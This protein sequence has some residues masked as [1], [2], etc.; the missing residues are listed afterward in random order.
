MDEAQ[1]SVLACAC[2][3]KPFGQIED[4]RLKLKCKHCGREESVEF[5]PPQNCNSQAMMRR[6]IRKRALEVS[7]EWNRSIL[8]AK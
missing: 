2:G 6:E 4:G 7:Q 3:H 1:S 5:Q 8:L